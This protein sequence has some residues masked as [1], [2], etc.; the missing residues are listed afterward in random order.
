MLSLR[1]LV[2]LV[3]MFA[4]TAPLVADDVDVVRSKA[5]AALL[6][7]QSQQEQEI[8]AKEKQLLRNKVKAG[9]REDGPVAQQF[10]KAGEMFQLDGWWY[11]ANGKGGGTFC[12][13]CHEEFVRGPDGEPMLRISSPA[14]GVP[15]RTFRKPEFPL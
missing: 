8:K 15:D 2:A 14:S 4:L 6:L 11:R 1:N 7:C 12:Y 10:R 5:R 3:V 13:H 9:I